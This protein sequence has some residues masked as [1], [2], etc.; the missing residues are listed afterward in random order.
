MV[1]DKVE[2]EIRHQMMHVCDM[3]DVCVVCVMCVCMCVMVTFFSSWNLLPA[4]KSRLKK[5]QKG[6]KTALC[7]Q[8]ETHLRLLS[9]AHNDNQTWIRTFQ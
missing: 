2:N 5:T 6:T 4:L 1:R 3:C 7:V 8:L 9:Q